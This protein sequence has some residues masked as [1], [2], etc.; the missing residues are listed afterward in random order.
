MSK[1]T[2]AAKFHVKIIVMYMPLDFRLYS[3]KDLG[4]VEIISCQIDT[5][6]L[7]IKFDVKDSK[8]K[9][10]SH[11]LFSSKQERLP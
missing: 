8:T 2:I 1:G 6:Q 11:I 9:P 3:I 4:I 5:Q 10:P 7:Y